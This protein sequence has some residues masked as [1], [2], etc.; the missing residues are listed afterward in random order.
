MDNASLIGTAVLTVIELA[1]FI[2]VVLK[3]IQPINELRIAIQKLID[4]LDHEKK[5]G[6]LRDKRITEHGKEIDKLTGRV[7]KLE[8][9]INMFHKE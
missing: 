3:F 1:A 4:S 9:K 5:A 7:D 2:G 6:E 8:T